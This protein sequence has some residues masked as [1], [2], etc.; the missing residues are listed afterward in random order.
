MLAKG[1]DYSDRGQAYYE[2]HYR[3]RVIANL[4]RRSQQLGLQV[5]AGGAAPHTVLKS[6]RQVKCLTRISR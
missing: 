5:R 6:A 4:N 1:E 3:Q 2:E